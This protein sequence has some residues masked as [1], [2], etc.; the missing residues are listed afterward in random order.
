MGVCQ[1]NNQSA[2]EGELPQSHQSIPQQPPNQ[3][4]KLNAHPQ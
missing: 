2:N 1:N 3:Q 4:Q